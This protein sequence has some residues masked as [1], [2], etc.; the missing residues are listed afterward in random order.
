M[1][2]RIVFVPLFVLILLLA[3]AGCSSHEEPVVTPAPTTIPTTAPAPLPTPVPTTRASLI[4]EPV[5]T[6][7]AQWPVSVTVEKSGLYSRT[8][9]THY[10]GG[11]GLAYTA[12]MDVRVT[13]PDGTVTTKSMTKPGMGDTVEIMGSEG[14]DRVEVFLLMQ[15]GNTYRIIDQLMPY[16]GR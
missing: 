5:D 14:A 12:R 8:I 9:I 16:K 6:L 10:D 1:D 11:K 13:T 2:Y 7:P 4:P 15:N 3:V